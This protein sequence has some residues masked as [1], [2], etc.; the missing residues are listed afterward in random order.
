MGVAAE[1]EPPRSL[2]AR[3]SAIDGGERL[4]PWT[5]EWAERERGLQLAHCRGTSHEPA[6]E[7]KFARIFAE[8]DAYEGQCNA[9]LAEAGYP[10]LEARSQGLDDRQDDVINAMIAMRATTPAGMLAK[11]KLAVE[12]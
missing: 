12:H 1:P 10:Q 9:M 2:M 6:I 5:R 7:A 3:I 8:L 11:L 4:R